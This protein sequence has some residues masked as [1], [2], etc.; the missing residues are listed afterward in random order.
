MIQTPIH[1]VLSTIRKH[2]VKSL[3]MGGQACIFYGAA[4]FSRDTDLVILAD[5][6]NIERLTAAVEEL[7][8]E[9]IAVP[10]FAKEYLDRGHSIHFACRR[11]DVKR[12]RLDVMSKMRGVDPFPE[13]WERR[14]TATLPDMGTVEVVALP[15][16][17]AAKKTQRDKDWPMVRRLVE[18]NY[19]AFRDQPTPAHIEFWLR[20]L[21]TP[22]LLLEVA[23]EHPAE[24]ASVAVS[25][26][27][28]KAA[29]GGVSAGIETEIAAEEAHERELDRQYWAPLR[30]ELERLRH[31][32]RRQQEG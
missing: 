8:A 30:A 27:V 5:T 3:L 31:A 29:I 11:A 12:M 1:K 24:A 22:E 4:E 28:V 21:R 23:R 16:L 26:P 19:F 18:A 9:V 25:R 14:T 13:L 32:A 6:A 20:E 10:P 7:E 17:V 15:D 2:D